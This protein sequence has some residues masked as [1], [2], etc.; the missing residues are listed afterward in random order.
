[1][2]YFARSV[3]VI[4]ALLATLAMA[5]AGSD[6]AAKSTTSPVATQ[7]PECSGA[8]VSDALDS[9]PQEWQ[10]AFSRLSSTPRISL[11]AVISDMQ[12]ARRRLQ[13]ADFPACAANIKRTMT[14]AYDEAIDGALAF[15]ADK[16]ESVAVAHFEKSTTLIKRVNALVGELD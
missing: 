4:V 12:A 5:C 10:D 15:Q 9:I 1:M 11:G 13:A 14:D 3:V 2:R 7:K 6:D 16:P 8:D